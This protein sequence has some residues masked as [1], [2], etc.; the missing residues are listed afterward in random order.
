MNA[1]KKIVLGLAVAGA[2]F[3]VVGLAL[4]RTVQVERSIVVDAPRATVFTVLNGFRQFGKWSPWAEIDPDATTAFAGPAV[5]VG[6]KMSWSGNDEVG[7]GTQEIVESVPY[8]RIA[9]R[10]VFGDFPGTFSA[11]FELED[12]GGA[13]RVRW[14]FE[15]DYGG[16]IVGR[17]FGVLAERMIGPDYERGLARLKS[18]V[19]QLPKGDFAALKVVVVE[20]A[21]DPVV[22]LSVRS[23]DNPNAIG[24]ALGVAY[25]RLSGYMSAAGLKQTAA[26]IAVYRHAEQGTLT[27]DAAI[28]VDR[29]DAAPAG[30]VR[31]ARLPA[32]PAL[33]AEYQGAYAGLA[34]TRAQLVAYLAA[35]GIEPAGPTWEQYVSDPARTPEAQLITHIFVPVRSSL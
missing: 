33:R 22:Q 8:E 4:P 2:L 13:T 14:I 34:A 19:E 9:L 10:L 1:L 18:L 26:P 21:A 32:G 28:P 30:P 11:R 27:L 12:E 23:M 25:S 29:G 20:T 15:G 3:I 24:V 35:A 7:S 17:W 16:S 5:G 6:A 31:L